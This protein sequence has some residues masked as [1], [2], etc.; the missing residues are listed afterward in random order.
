MFTGRAPR[1]MSR[2]TSAPSAKDSERPG[3]VAFDRT[4][5]R[6]V[7]FPRGRLAVVVTTRVVLIRHGEGQYSMDRVVGGPSGCTGLSERGREQVRRLTDRLAG[8]GELAANLL[9]ASVLRR[10]IDT[11]EAIAPTV[12]ADVTTDCSFCE[13]HVG[14]ADGLT[15]EEAGRRWGWPGPWETPPEGAETIAAFGHR[16]ATAMERLVDEHAG[17][18]SVVVTHGGF[19]SAACYWLLG[20]PW[21]PERSRSERRFFLDPSYTGISQWTQDDNGPWLLDRYNDT[22]HLEG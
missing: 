20:V 7:G 4:V 16:V 9:V 5:A 8:A 17:R 10:A 18:T 19:I 3:G 2:S 22:A 11:A 12:G 13:V 14:V 6:W 1:A 15:Y 21:Q